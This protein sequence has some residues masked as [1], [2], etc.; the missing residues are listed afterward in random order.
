ME[1]ALRESST[2]RYLLRLYMVGDSPKTKA[3][4]TNYQELCEK[5]LKGRSQPEVLDISKN[6]PAPTYYRWPGPDQ[7]G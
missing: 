5:P 4:I 6:S 7:P 1:N 2:A 3:T